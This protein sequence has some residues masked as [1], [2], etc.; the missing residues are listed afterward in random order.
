[1]DKEMPQFV[2]KVIE[3]YP[4][5][6]N[7]YDS[8]KEEIRSIDALDDKTQSLVKLAIAIGARREGAVHSHTRRCRKAGVTDEELFHTAL[9]AVTTIGWSGAMAGLSWVND[10]VDGL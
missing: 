9:Q 2:R 4:E 8:L 3:R 1:M 5:V 6:W 10:V 7:K